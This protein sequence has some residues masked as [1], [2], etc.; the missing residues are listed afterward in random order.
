[1]RNNI[2]SNFT[3]SNRQTGK[4]FVFLVPYIILG[5]SA[6]FLVIYL[7]RL[8]LRFQIAIVV[9]IVAVL[10]GLV[11]KNHE[12]LFR[13]LLALLALSIPFNLGVNFFYRPHIGTSSIAISL[14]IVL[15]F[16]L[17]LLMAYKRVLIGKM[18]FEFNKTLILPVLAYML[19][20]ILSLL[21][22]DHPDLVGLDIVRMLTLLG[23]LLVMMNLK[24]EK[25]VRF[26]LLFLLLGVLMQ[27]IIAGVQYYTDKPLGLNILGEEKTLEA[28]DLGYLV[29]RAGGTIGHP[30]ILAYYF[31]ILLP[32]N[33]ALLLVEPKFKIR[34]YLLGTLG[35]GLA[36]FV[37]TL[38]RGGWVTIPISFSI[39]FFVLFKDRFFRLSTFFILFLAGCLLLGFLYLAFPVIE[40]RL[41]VDDYQSA[42]SRIPMNEATFS[43][44]KRFPVVGAGLNNFPE[45]FHKYDQTG[46]SRILGGKHVVHNLFLWVWAEIGTIGLLAF[47][48]I[49]GSVFFVIRSLLSK[50]DPWFKGLLTG[51]GAGLFAHLFHGLVDPGFKVNLPTSV[52]VYALIGLVGAVSIQYRRQ[53]SIKGDISA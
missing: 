29:S 8:A 49:F 53:K 39:V 35:V 31:E 45:F 51:I 15:V 5:A 30:N 41:T 23:I 11:V 46:K 10:S 16:I 20:G 19:A 21:N 44:I 9:G 14:S 48:W 17:F 4:Y 13:I 2:Y 42:A 37:A 40:K 47:L 50:V 32:L 18:Y 3:D 34:L 27:G 24:N 7:D 36:A 38:S 6:G 28:Q 52:L 43:I 25:Q 26:F 33:L 12:K 1:M 22:A